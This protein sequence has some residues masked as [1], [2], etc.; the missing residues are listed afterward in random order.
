MSAGKGSKPRPH[1][2]YN[3]YVNNW[4]E[5]KWNKSDQNMSNSLVERTR[6]KELT[7]LTE[8]EFRTLKKMGFLWEFF[9]EATGNYKEDCLR[10]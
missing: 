2:N 1:S 5:I 4:D 3:T 10:N 9:P 7:D 6:N 8:R